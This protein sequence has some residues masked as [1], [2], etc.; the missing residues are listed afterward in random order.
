[1]ELDWDEMAMEAHLFPWLDS[2]CMADD[3]Q[4]DYYYEE[5]EE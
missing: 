4:D 3:Y 2:D 1:M 5:D